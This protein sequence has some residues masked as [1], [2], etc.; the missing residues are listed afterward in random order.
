MGT[1]REDWIV[2][3][4]GDRSAVIKNDVAAGVRWKLK[5]VEGD[6]GRD[7]GRVCKSKTRYYVVGLVPSAKPSKSSTNVEAAPLF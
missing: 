2:K 1:K 4:D 6:P 5:L 7:D 3:G